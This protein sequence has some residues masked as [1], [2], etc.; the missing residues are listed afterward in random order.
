MGPPAGKGGKIP[1]ILALF[2]QREACSAAQGHSS[3]EGLGAGCWRGEPT[4]ARGAEWTL[5]LAG[6][7]GLMSFVPQV[8]STRTGT[9]A[10]ADGL[11]LESAEQKRRVLRVAPWAS[12]TVQGP[13]WQE[14]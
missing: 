2:K 3:T 5:A 11:S 10:G 13:G 8:S 4:K 1:G 12:L 14:P 9:E 6:G 7:R